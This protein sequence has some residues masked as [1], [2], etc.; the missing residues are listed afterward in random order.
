MYTNGLPWKSRHNT[1]NGPT[2]SSC[3]FAGPELCH[4]RSLVSFLL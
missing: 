4:D 3:E 2:K 1:S